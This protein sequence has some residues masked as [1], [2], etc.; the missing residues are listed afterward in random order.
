MSPT[1]WWVTKKQC[2]LYLKNITLQDVLFITKQMVNL[3]SL[4][5]AIETKGTALSSKGQIISLTL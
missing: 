3:F 1:T 5:K 2:K 4:T